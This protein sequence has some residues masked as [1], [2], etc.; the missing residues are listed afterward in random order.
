MVDG[1]S[2]GSIIVV[3]VDL[4]GCLAYEVDGDFAVAMQMLC[5]YICAMNYLYTS[6]GPYGRKFQKF[7]DMS[8]MIFGTS[9]AVLF[10]KYEVS[11]HLSFIYDRPDSPL[12]YNPPCAFPFLYSSTSLPPK[13][14]KSLKRSKSS[15]G[16]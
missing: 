15:R 11:A 10:I 16:L 2:L 8:R 3:R 4:A 7:T 6:R 5:N 14:K 12:K 1:R 13:P 9:N